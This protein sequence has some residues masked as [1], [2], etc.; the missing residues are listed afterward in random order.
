MGEECS[1]TSELLRRVNNPCPNYGGLLWV[2]QVNVVVGEPQ[3]IAWPENQFNSIQQRGLARVTRSYETDA[4]TG[5]GPGCL[6]DTTEV[7]HFD[8]MYSH[9]ALSPPRNTWDFNPITWREVRHADRTTGIMV[10]VDVMRP[11]RDRDP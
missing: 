10:S 11:E 8:L 5:D 2:R 6:A 3:G 7:L 4:V 9:G 1:V